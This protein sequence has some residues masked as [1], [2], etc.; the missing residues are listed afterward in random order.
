MVKEVVVK[1]KLLPSASS[2]IVVGSE[3][4]SIKYIFMTCKLS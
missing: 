3:V 2:W 4:P 1:K